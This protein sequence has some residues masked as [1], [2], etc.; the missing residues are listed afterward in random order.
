MRPAPIFL[1]ETQA[2]R[3]VLSRKATPSSR[4]WASLTEQRRETHAPPFPV[5]VCGAGCDDFIG[6]LLL[7]A[8]LLSSGL[9]SGLA[10]P[11]LWFLLPGSSSLLSRSPS[12]LPVA[13]RPRISDPERNRP[14]RQLA[15][16]LICCCNLHFAF[17]ITA[18]SEFS[19]SPTCQS[20]AR[21]SA[22]L[23]G[24]DRVAVDRRAAA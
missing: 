11:R 12:L 23:T 24:L 4:R 15:G 22:A 1:D 17:C 3:A 20:V 9:A 7:P 10:S 13:A 2:H 14:A 19:S 16:L 6:R 5:H 21:L 18:S 8:H